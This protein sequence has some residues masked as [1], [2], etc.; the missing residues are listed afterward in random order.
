[1]RLSSPAARIAL[2]ALAFLPLFLLLH[3]AYEWLPWPGLAWFSSTGETV[4]SHMKIAFF[5]YL[6]LCGLEYALVRPPASGRDGFLYSR[7]FASVLLPWGIFFGWYLGPAVY[8]APMPNDAIEIV[9][10]NLVTL[11]VL[12]LVGII[13][14]GLEPYRLPRGL[15]A[16]L[17]IIAA[18]L[19]LEFVI[20]S[21]RQPWADVFTPPPGWE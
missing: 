21:Y 3:Y 18:V 6:V 17:W 1:M 11:G 9:Y 2:K 8:G 4:Y 13:E 7:L 10:A 15:R 16:A 19:V 14:R 5:A 12:A 20:F